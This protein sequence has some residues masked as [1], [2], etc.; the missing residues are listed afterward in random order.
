[1]NIHKGANMITLQ[2]DYE[3]CLIFFHFFHMKEFLNEIFCNLLSNIHIV[4]LIDH[5][6]CVNHCW[7]NMKISKCVNFAKFCISSWY[8]NFDSYQNSLTTLGFCFLYHKLQLCFIY[9]AHYI[10]FTC[11][12]GLLIIL[13][14]EK[15]FK[16]LRILNFISY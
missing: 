5:M 6:F 14:F 10:P 8:H 1:M 4:A 15:Y 3:S 2:K 7:I 16:F 9:H 13:K 11:G 12:K